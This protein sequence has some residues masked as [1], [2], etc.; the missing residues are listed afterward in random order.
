MTD[1]M[2]SDDMGRRRNEEG[3]RGMCRMCRQGEVEES[4]FKF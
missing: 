4:F 3:R 2:N 1:G